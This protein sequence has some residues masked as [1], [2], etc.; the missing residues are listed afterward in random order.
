[1]KL[2]GLVIASA[3]GVWLSDAATAQVLQDKIRKAPSPDTAWYM[4]DRDNLIAKFAEGKLGQTISRGECTDLVDAA[5]AA[6][7][8]KPGSNY[9]WG[10]AVATPR[11]GYIIQFWDT[12]FTSPNGSTWGTAK[13]G[14]HTAIVASAKGTEVT[15]V[16]QNDGERKVSKRTIDLAW[17]HTGTYKIYQAVRP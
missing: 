17:T 12:Q 7:K 1:M 10:R 3:I 4:V 8:A 13:G 16:H 9:V 2:P 5:L 11:R 14:Q 15:L 6:V